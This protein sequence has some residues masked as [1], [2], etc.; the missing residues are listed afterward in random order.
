MSV[1]ARINVLIEVCRVREH[2]TFDELL[3]IGEAPLIRTKRVITFLA[4]LEMARLRLVRI[5]QPQAGGTI[6]VTP[7]RE[8]LDVDASEIES[9]FDTPAGDESAGE[10]GYTDVQ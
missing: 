3:T 4:L 10:T 9:N 5:H 2:I 8:N 1:G 6:Y 7:I